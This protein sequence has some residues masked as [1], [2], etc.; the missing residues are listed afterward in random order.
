MEDRILFG[1]FVRIIIVAAWRRIIV[2]ITAWKRT[3]CTWPL[4]MKKEEEKT[5]VEVAN[6]P[7][8]VSK[9]STSREVYLQINDRTEHIIV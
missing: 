2:I 5:N 7:T 9:S 6:R 4:V 3:R 8:W 1:G